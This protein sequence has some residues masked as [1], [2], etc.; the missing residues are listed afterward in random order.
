M[1]GKHR[2]GELGEP[3]NRTKERE[4]D[5]G[6]AMGDQSGKRQGAGESGQGSNRSERD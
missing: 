2:E 6:W 4:K 5:G 3:P 1:S